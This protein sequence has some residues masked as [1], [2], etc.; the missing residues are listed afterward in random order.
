M[1]LVNSCVIALHALPI[2]RPVF[3]PG[4]KKYICP[5]IQ[6]RKWRNN[7]YHVYSKM[8]A[9]IVS[10]IFRGNDAI[11][12]LKPDATLLLNKAANIFICKPINHVQCRL[13]NSPRLICRNNARPMFGFVRFCS[14]GVVVLR[15]CINL[16]SGTKSIIKMNQRESKSTSGPAVLTRLLCFGSA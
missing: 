4:V 8:P 2:L 11:M 6:K 12:I 14:I 9:C 15:S 10:S 3:S 7:V 5:K 1:E 16:P 13:R